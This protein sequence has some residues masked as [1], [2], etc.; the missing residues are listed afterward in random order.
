MN[1]TSMSEFWSEAATYQF[2]GM[3]ST[4]LAKTAENDWRHIGQLQLAKHLQ[5]SRI[6]VTYFII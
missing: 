1:P 6:L 4:E 2:L 3:H 5:L